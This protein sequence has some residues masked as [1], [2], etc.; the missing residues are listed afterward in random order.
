[1]KSVISSLICSVKAEV[2]V[3][4]PRTSDLLEAL[5]E[6]R[7]FG[8]N[9][10]PAPEQKIQSQLLVLRRPV[11]EDHT[12]HTRPP[13]SELLSSSS[14]LNSVWPRGWLLWE[15]RLPQKLARQLP[16][17]WSVNDLS[18]QQNY[19]RPRRK[20]L[21][22]RLTARLASLRSREFLLLLL[23]NL[24]LRPR[25]SLLPHPPDTVASLKLIRRLQ[26]R[27]RKIDLLANMSSNSVRRNRWSKS[28]MKS[29]YGH[30][31]NEFIGMMQRNRRMTLPRSER[32]L[33]PGSRPL[34]N[35]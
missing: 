14:R 23:S 2:P 15:S 1:M 19:A 33:K 21:A 8:R 32:L 6:P 25:S 17:A 28:Y 26:S 4:V 7:R 9:V 16:S 10:L 31:T 3:S 30:G 27:L 22:G 34:R 18:E 12:P 11:L 20:M 29:P 35:K 5:H 13:R 24:R